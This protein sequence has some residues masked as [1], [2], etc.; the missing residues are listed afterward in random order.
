MANFYYPIALTQNESEGQVIAPFSDSVPSP[1]EITAAYV[2]TRDIGNL[3]GGMYVLDNGTWRFVIPLVNISES[4][5]KGDDIAIY[6]DLSEDI[7]LTDGTV[8]RNGVLA[9]TLTLEAGP[10]VYGV[11]RVGS[12]GGGVSAVNGKTGSVSI[13]AGSN[14]TVNSSGSSIIISTPSDIDEG[15]YT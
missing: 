15:T 9:N 4:I 10:N 13:A 11:R 2:L 8:Y 7:E 5:I 3:P 12:A 14:I 1:S 6:F